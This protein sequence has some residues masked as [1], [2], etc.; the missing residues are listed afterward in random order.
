MKLLLKKIQQPSFRIIS[1]R[2]PVRFSGR[3]LYA[4]NHCYPFSSNG[5][6]VRTHGVAAGL[7]HAGCEVVA[8]ARPGTPWDRPSFD[9]ANGVHCH[10]LDG[11]RYLHTRSPSPQGVPLGVYIEQ[12]AA[13]LTQMAR[14]YKPVAIMAASN[15]HNALPA[16]LA[17]RALG[18]PFFYEV[19]GF[20][21]VSQAARDPGWEHSPSFAQE[22]AGE[23]AVAQSA[24]RVF[25]LNRFM[26]DD[27]VR[28][29]VSAQRIDLVPNGFP[30]WEAAPAQPVSRQGL[31]IRSRHVM[32]YIG[33][34]NVYEGLELLIEAL[35]LVRGQG[36]DV[37]LLLVGSGEPRGLALG[38]TEAC[39][40]TMAY[41]QL[42]Q[43]LGVA[44]HV[45]MPGRVAPEQAAAYYALLD[46]VVVP[47]QPWAVC[48]LVSP[49][50]PLEAAAHGKRVLMSD[51]APLA[52]LASLYPGFSYFSKGNVAALARQLTALL[53]APAHPPPRTDALA[54]LIWNNNV[55]PMATAIHAL[56]GVRAKSRT[57]SLRSEHF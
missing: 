14:V 56:P 22:V 57:A 6:A 44:E 18:L 27:L 55:Q 30:G 49:M 24:Q 3:V 50:K 52:D 5:Y 23:T 21:E 54:R 41:R 16:A 45:I 46:V 47:R 1:N 43:R 51:V 48:E 25:T 20:W 39:P 29:G 15:W 26:R 32:G 8:V 10:V 40:Q 19:R 7:V 42:A 13:A 33:S 9:D 36:L 35:A 12:S 2:L 37:T 53:Q 4:V 38:Q 34:F 31:G 28:R 11:V 17:A